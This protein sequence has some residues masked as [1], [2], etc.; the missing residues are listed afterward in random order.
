MTSDYFDVDEAD[1]EVNLDSE[2]DV[3]TLKL[4]LN[5]RGTQELLSSYKA[6]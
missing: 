5:G 1:S 4:T 3:E 2:V 6:L